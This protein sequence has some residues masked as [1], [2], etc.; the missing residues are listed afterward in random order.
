MGA[1]CVQGFG[2]LAYVQAV[3]KLVMLCQEA[4]VLAGEECTSTEKAARV[5]GWGLA[6]TP[7]TLTEAHGVS[8]GVAVAARSFRQAEKVFGFHT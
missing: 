4:R 7:A 8:A 3:D 5:S 6:I 1:A 2:L